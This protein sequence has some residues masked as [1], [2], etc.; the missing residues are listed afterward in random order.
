MLIF[1]RVCGVSLKQVIDC[2]DSTV[3]V[4]A[5]PKVTLEA[6]AFF[7]LVIPIPLLVY[8]WR[9]KNWLKAQDWEHCVNPRT[10]QVD[11]S[12][13][14]QRSEHRKWDKRCAAMVSRKTST[15]L[16]ALNDD[17]CSVLY[18]VIQLG[19]VETAKALL[20]RVPEVDLYPELSIESRGVHRAQGAELSV[21]PKSII[22]RLRADSI[23]RFRC[24]D[25]AAI[26]DAILEAQTRL[27]TS[28]TTVQDSLECLH[29]N[30]PKV[31]I[32]YLKPPEETAAKL[33]N[34]AIAYKAYHLGCTGTLL[35]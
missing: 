6:F 2:C 8:I 26:S 35:R 19:A 3:L 24:T 33:S 25:L 1:L 23:D 15:G 34:A 9:Q 5:P 22:D 13:G 21:N 32:E 4:A 31:V 17:G 28:Y 10:S 18:N 7:Y 12:G 20:Q 14:C 11:Y 16:S 30:L 29:P 27:E